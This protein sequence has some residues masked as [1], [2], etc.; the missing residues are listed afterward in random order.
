M[1]QL[2]SLATLRTHNEEKDDTRNTITENN[3]HV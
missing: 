2:G 1:V 3:T